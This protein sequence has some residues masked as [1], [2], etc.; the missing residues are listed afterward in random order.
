MSKRLSETNLKLTNKA[1]SMPPHMNPLR[2]GRL[3]K[4]KSIQEQVKDF[5]GE[6]FSLRQILSQS[7]N[8]NNE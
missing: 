5:N 3:Y 1:F 6:Q 4:L 7:R 8:E 2:Q